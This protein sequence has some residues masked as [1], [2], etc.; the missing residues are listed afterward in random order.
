[1]SLV[2]AERASEEHD[3]ILV[4]AC[5][6]GIDCRYDGESC[7]NARV[8]ALATRGK[9]MSKETLPEDQM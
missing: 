3:L 1:M 9:V 6:L 4:S 8:S 5:L 2:S 7:P